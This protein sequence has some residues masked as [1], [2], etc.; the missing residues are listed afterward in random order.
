MNSIDIISKIKKDLINNDIKAIQKYKL[1]LI[2]D[3]NIRDTNDKELIKCYNYHVKLIRKIK[4]YL[5]GSTGYD[6]IIN[7]KEH[8]KSNLIT[9]VS[10]INPN[11]INIG[12]SVDIRLLTGSRDESYMDCTYYPSQSTIYIND[13]R[14]SISNRGYG[15]IILDNLDEILEHLNKILEKHCLNRIMIIRGKM[16]ANKHIISEENLKKMYIKYGFEV[17]NSNNILKVLNEII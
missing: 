12:I 15:K 2:K 3:C 10:K 5:K 9:L 6:I 17:D 14:S 8:Q 4:K 13:F 11:E 1:Q 16:I 7:A